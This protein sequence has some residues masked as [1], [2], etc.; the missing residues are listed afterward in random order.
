MAAQQ[1][2]FAPKVHIGELDQARDLQAEPRRCGSA[3]QLMRS[4]FSVS[5]R[6][7]CWSSMAWTPTMHAWLRVAT[8]VTA[9]PS[10]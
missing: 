6:I 7:P 5:I 10:M 4:S 9:L 1:A 3:R 8:L 2:L